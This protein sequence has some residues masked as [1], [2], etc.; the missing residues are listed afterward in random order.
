MKYT[1]FSID[2][3]KIEFHNS[4]LRK[5]TILISGSKISE[6]YSI[7]GTEHKIVKN[8]FK[9]VS[10]Y[11]LFADRIVNLLIEKNGKIVEEEY[12]PT[13]LKQRIYWMKIRLL[14]KLSGFINC[15]ISTK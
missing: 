9:V 13:N 11:K 2:Q 1:E 14:T 15:Y 6:K 10:E 8:N 4:I 3:N 12:V 5:E 7:T